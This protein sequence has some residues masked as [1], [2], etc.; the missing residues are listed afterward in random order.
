MGKRMGQN[1]VHFF[2]LV[3]LQRLTR[4][5]SRLLI[6]FGCFFKQAAFVR[7]A[8]SLLIVL[9]VGVRA[10]SAATVAGNLNN[11]VLAFNGTCDAG[12]PTVFNVSFFILGDV[13]DGGGNDQF[14]LYM[15]DGSGQV[16]SGGQET[17]P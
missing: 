14:T 17:V 6:E 13:D 8:I 11:V 3:S 2:R 16:L 12:T 10:V 1:Q 15:L 7:S 5:I 9:F 4:P